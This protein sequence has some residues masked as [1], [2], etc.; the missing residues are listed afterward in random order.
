MKK[1][2]CKKNVNGITLIALIVTIIILFI[3]AGVSIILTKDWFVSHAVFAVTKTAEEMLKE[4]IEMIISET[5]MTFQIEKYH[6][7]D[8]DKKIFYENYIKF[9]L[10]KSDD[11]KNII[12]SFDENENINISYQYKSQN[13]SFI[14]SNGGSVNLIQNLKGNVKVGD[15]IEYPINYID[16]FSNDSYLYSK[17]AW[18][19]INDGVTDSANPYIKIV[20]TGIPVK[21][22]HNISAIET[23]SKFEN[24]FED[25]EL[26]DYDWNELTGNDF[27]NKNLATKVKALNL[28]ELNYA[29]N[30]LNKTSR[31]LLCTDLL[32]TSDTLFYTSNKNVKYWLATS[33]DSELMYVEHEKIRSTSLDY[34]FGIKIVVYLKDDLKGYFQ[35][36]VWK[37]VN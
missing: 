21:Y 19:I 20:S 30:V 4:N 8:L 25:V 11:F 5:N 1:S 35:D 14:V 29:Y 22:Y 23:V 33:K 37:I 15:S 6:H 7:P 17:N 34:R 10:E 12:V 26:L 32:D 16:V 28:E 27:L 13:Y 3:L 31:N 18:T 2:Y 24:N 9:C 36:G